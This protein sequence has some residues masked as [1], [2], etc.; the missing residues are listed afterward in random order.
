MLQILLSIA[1]IFLLIVLGHGLRRGGI[2][3]IEFWNLND[4]LVY[5]VLFP[6]LLFHKTST[7]TLSGDLVLPQAGVMYGALACAVAFAL[8]AA[9]LARYEGP[10]AS[11]LLQGCARHN[12]FIALAVSERLYGAEGLAVAALTTA[13]LVPVTNVVVVT[14]MVG[15]IRGGGD[16]VLKAIARDLARN[17]L[18]LAVLAGGAWNLAGVGHAPVLHDMTRILGDAALPV[19][20]LCVGANIRV[21][22][23]AAQLLPTVLSM[24]G[25][26]VVFPAAVI[27]LALWTGLPSAAALVALVYGAV[28]TAPNGF[29]LARQMGGDAPVM[30]GMIT[31]QTVIAFVTLPLT[32]AVGQRLL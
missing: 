25:R 28:S 14:L 19:V 17:P 20:L 15:L 5:W 26:M 8:I 10:L 23:M 13:L 4:R 1:P 16:G 21:R 9:R 7:T 27:G 31:L 32:M 3:S 24:A 6:A 2:P 22:A 12:T 11:S 30:A 18:L 29:T